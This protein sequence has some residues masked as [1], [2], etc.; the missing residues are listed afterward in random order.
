ML[1]R[2]AVQDGM[3]PSRST[4]CKSSKQKC[5]LSV[6]NPSISRTYDAGEEEEVREGF[7]PD[8]P[9][10]K[11]KP[12]QKHNLDAP[13]AVGDDE[14]SGEGAGESEEQSRWEH[15]DYEREEER[16]GANMSSRYGSFREER[17]VW[18]SDA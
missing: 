14:D 4:M 11:V 15:R 16:G 17:N 13:F 2:K 6:A 1:A 3:K 7:E 10:M 9:P 8:A 18:G 5:F 12:G